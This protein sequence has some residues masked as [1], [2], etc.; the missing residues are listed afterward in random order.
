MGKLILGAICAV[1]VLLP[2]PG[3]SQEPA[4]ATAYIYVTYFVCNPTGEAR[5][6]EIIARNFKPHYDA[7]VEGGN[8]V[9]WSWLAHYVGGQWRRAHVIAAT[10]MDD[11]LDASG[12]LGE[13][14]EGT[15]PEAGRAFTEVCSTHEDYIWETVDGVGS[16]I[17]GG[18]RGDAGY[19]MYF[20]CDVTREQRADELMAEVFAP[21]YD[22][23]VESGQLVSWA[24]L[25]H[26]VGGTYRRLLSMTG[27]DHKS[28]ARV[29]AALLNEFGTRRM[30]R[31][32][33]EMGTICPTHED[34]MWDIRIETP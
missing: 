12:A 25:R 14:I 21:V 10:N 26:N 15:T 13:I 34:Y 16:G 30:E 22:R 27:S 5:A 19:S 24:W 31:P 11:L 4:P 6:D 23:Y 29:R 2:V 20:S 17:I 8:L 32:Y 9:S 33:R 18:E 7:A 28:L 1:A 3:H